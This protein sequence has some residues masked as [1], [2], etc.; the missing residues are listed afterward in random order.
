[1]LS[2]KFK[3]IFSVLL[4]MICSLSALALFQYSFLHETRE[5][6]IEETLFTILEGTE[7]TIQS[8][9][10]GWINLAESTTQTVEHEFSPKSIEQIV[11]QKGLKE[12][13]VAAGIGIESD[14]SIIENVPSWFPDASWDSRT[15]PWYQDAKQEDSLVI[16]DPYVDVNTNSLMVS[17]SVPVHKGNELLGVTFFDVSLHELSQKVNKISPLHAGY[18]FLLT[19]DGTFITHPNPSLNG[20]HVNESYRKLDL[21]KS[22]QKMEVDGEKSTVYL[23]S[24][25]GHD[26]IIGS[27]LND[28]KLYE[29][30]DDLRDQTI[31]YLLLVVVISAICIGLLTNFLLR[32]LI[33]ITNDISRM[34]VSG[35]KKDLTRRLDTSID[36][37][38]SL[39]AG[40]YNGFVDMLQHNIHQSKEFAQS[41]G[42]T[43]NT[44]VNNS[45]NSE[46]A[47]SKQQLEI[48]QLATALNQMSVTSSD[49]AQNTQLAA[50]SAND[51]QI[52]STNGVSS[53]EDADLVINDLSQKIQSSVTEVEEL[54]TSS[55][56]IKKILAMISDISDQTNLLALNAAIEAA[57]AGESGRGFAVVADEVRML[58][59][60]TQGA[61]MEISTIISSLEDSTSLL[62]KSMNECQQQARSATDS[63]E[64]VGKELK[65][66]N[67]SIETINDMNIQIAS[68]AEEQSL[69]VE[70]INVNA[71][72]IREFSKK[73]T[74]S[75]IDTRF[76]VEN[77]K[78]QSDGDK[79]LNLF[80]V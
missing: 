78:S 26:W 52:A 2:F 19:Q 72:N 62:G 3:L 9:I 25:P 68:A 36:K 66:I 14:G 31:F 57:R 70:E 51:A 29:S 39:I 55:G 69:V 79:T 80:V 38:F 47:I 27:V 45:Q 71:L 35:E 32:P 23:S 12:H 44:A 21:S 20:K 10:D 58:A 22:V 65:H 33:N 16:T 41:L 6:E 1:M 7:N 60:R 11:E 13:F 76:A 50:S 18:L 48:E 30:L 24:L 54:A 63:I 17:I 4:L 40:A 15:R 28:E 74:E 64:L 56:N 53:A 46:E 49:M 75:V 43:T 73:V 5:D 77:L 8:D 42:L 34:S 37:E 61:T 67:M 59:Q